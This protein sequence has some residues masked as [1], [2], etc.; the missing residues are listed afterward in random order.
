MLKL[1]QPTLS[2]LLTEE[3]ILLCPFQKCATFIVLL[4][5]TKHHN[6]SDHMIQHCPTIPSSLFNIKK[7][8]CKN[9][10][11]PLSYNS[12]PDNDSGH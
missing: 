4:T 5:I 3:A 10:L 2:V 11:L 1:I 9:F 7:W 12:E 6:S 8:Y